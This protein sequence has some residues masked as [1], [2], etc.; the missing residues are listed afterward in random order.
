MEDANGTGRA[1]MLR[2]L[3]SI[4]ELLNSQTGLA[5][6]REVGRKRAVSLAR[7]VLEDIR[8]K[9]G[10][11][12]SIK[13][14]SELIAEISVRLEN[15]LENRRRGWI[16][17]V[18]N[19]TGVIVHTILGRAP[20]SDNAAE[21]VLRAAGYCSLEFDFEIGKRGRRGASVE[22]VLAELTNAEDGLI[23]NNGAAAALLVLSTFANDGE[24][25]VSRGELVEIGGDFRIPDVLAQS[26]ATLREVGTTNRTKLAD[27]DR[28][29]SSQTKAILRVHPSNYRI[30][31]FTDRPDLP[32]LSALAKQNGLILI[33][34]AGSGA[35]VDV[36]KYGLTNE[37]VIAELIDNGADLVTFS[38]DKL[39]GGIQAG[40]IVG[41]GGLI[42]TLR[43]HPLY[44]ALR[45][46]KI[47]YAAIE[48]TLESYALD[49]ATT[50]V[51]V[52][53]ML[54]VDAE[55]LERRSLRVADHIRKGSDAKL[56]VD[57]IDGV[58]AIG[59]GAGPGIEL[60]TS[61]ISLSHHSISAEGFA[62]KLREGDP[63]VIL[64]IENE[65]VLID[66][67]TVAES[68]ECELTDAV[69]ASA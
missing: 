49:N 39:L 9:I 48:A 59:G 30:V 17:R 37:P 64:R 27:Y 43:K 8:N 20:I 6:V 25:I 50:E 23:V 62:A 51:P 46:S 63:P 66:L 38:G 11:N 42:Q 1:A 52:M 31:G 56:D 54:A 61:L 32:E 47:I 67:R 45:P 68:E 44:R 55:E 3:P 35:L 18:I 57:V 14:R 22:K 58:S 53:R 69:I 41:R 21:A 33:E 65:R 24:V 28:A 4:D 5:A 36:S 26:G 40:L 16:T 10:M 19:A 60:P 7:T 12:R 29:I 15:I 2:E 34:D 13:Q